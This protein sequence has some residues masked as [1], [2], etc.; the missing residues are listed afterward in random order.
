MVV[1][2]SVQ[3]VRNYTKKA[4]TRRLKYTQ[5][6][7]ACALMDMD[8]GATVR[9]TSVKYGIPTTTLHKRLHGQIQ[10]P[11]QSGRHTA[12]LMCEEQVIAQHLAV[13]GDF[14]LAFDVQDLCKFV[15]HYL[16]A[17]QRHIPQFKDNLPGIEW[18]NAFLLRHPILR[19]R[20]CQNIKRSRAAVSE[21]D[22]KEYFA[23]LEVSLRGVPGRNIINYD[24]TNL[25]DDPKSKQLIFRRGIKRAERVMNYSKTSTSLMFANT[26]TGDNL[27]VYVVYKGERLQQSWIAGGPASTFYNVSQSG[28]FDA[29]LFK[30]WMQSV[31]IPFVKTLPQDEPKVLIGDNLSSHI[32]LELVQL[33]EANQI[34]MV[35][36]PPNSTHLLQPLDVGL[37]APLKAAWR[38]TLSEF[39]EGPG[40]FMATLP[41]WCLPRLLLSVLCIMEPK[42]AHLCKSAFRTCG[43]YPVNAEAV[44]VKMR[45]ANR[46]APDITSVSPA[47]ISYLKEAREVNTPLRAPR[48]KALKITPGATATSA[49]L[50]DQATPGPSQKRQQKRKRGQV[51]Q[52]DG[53]QHP[54]RKRGCSREQ[55]EEAED[56]DPE[57]PQELEEEQV[58]VTPTNL[59]RNDYVLVSFTD[60]KKTHHFVGQLKT[61]TEK[62]DKWEVDFFRKCESGKCNPGQTMFRKPD[63][64]D[65]YPVNTSAIIMKLRVV[66]CTK[67]KVVFNNA[68]FSRLSVR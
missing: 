7:M 34:R 31:L 2:V 57:P 14:G 58:D 49:D 38:K 59:S 17:N 28:W 26:A 23:R 18:A 13:L 50:D 27:P 61:H 67:G 32:S 30:K 20:H 29:D 12:L 16:N 11:G 45:P 66:D 65:I 4:D 52:E 1:S 44:L 60:K 62:D 15:Q 55:Q 43:I 63:V 64:Q 5:D 47:F 8:A 3:M 10:Q 24:E 6:A 37:F 19:K 33:C 48:R 54:A 68:S 46:I 9:E 39:K 40:K 36:L 41:K 51:Q 25:T 35:F 53:R 22:V 42:W 56:E 21:E